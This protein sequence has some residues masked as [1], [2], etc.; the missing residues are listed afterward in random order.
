MLHC[1]GVLWCDILPVLFAVRVLCPTLCCDALRPGLHHA[2]VPGMLY[3]TWYSTVPYLSS[4]K[5]SVLF[6]YYPK[7]Q[8]YYCSM[9]VFNPFGTALP[10]GDSLTIIP[11]KLSPK[12]GCGSKICTLYS[13]ARGSFSLS[14]LR[15]T[16][17]GPPV[18]H[19]AS[20][21][22]GRAPWRVLS[23]FK[24]EKTD[25]LSRGRFPRT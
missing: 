20:S 13:G 1:C 9:C 12:Q 3:S 5:R 19:G 15:G 16:Q 11:S 7:S 23:A 2:I 6:Y 25:K 17:G 18:P 10:Y 24:V 22:P 8:L 4:D 14:R 21:S